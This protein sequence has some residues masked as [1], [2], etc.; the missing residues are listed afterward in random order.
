[1]TG[2]EP[3]GVGIRGNFEEAVRTS[4][5]EDVI[6]ALK[7]NDPKGVQNAVDILE[8]AEQDAADDVLLDLHDS[9]HPQI[10]ALLEALGL[11]VKKDGHYI[12]A[13]PAEDLYHS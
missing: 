1:M 10:E 7:S 11:V 3:K 9:G 6:E 12:E 2:D 13:K 5:K 4:L 8:G